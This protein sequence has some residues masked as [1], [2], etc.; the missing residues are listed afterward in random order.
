[1][2]TVD[3]LQTL[4]AALAQPSNSVEQAELLGALREAL[5]ARPQPLPILCATLMGTVNVNVEDS[6]LKR[7][8]L[9][10][11]HFGIARANLPPEQRTQRASNIVLNLNLQLNFICT[12][13]SQSL[14]TLAGLLVDP[15]PRIVKIAVQAFAGIYPLLFMALYVDLFPSSVRR[16]V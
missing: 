4:Q 12:V 6:L 10:L 8:V 13:A 15:T 14:E 9:D 5:E 3:P 1:M 11:I 2:A 7:F 16:R